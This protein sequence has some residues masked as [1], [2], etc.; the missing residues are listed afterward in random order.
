MVELKEKI[1]KIVAVELI[2]LF[3]L[4]LIKSF[5]TKTEGVICQTSMEIIVV[6]IP[7]AMLLYL[8]YKEKI[9]YVPLVLFVIGALIYSCNYSV[10][11]SVVDSDAHAYLFYISHGLNPPPYFGL[12]EGED[13]HYSVEIV[14]LSLLKRFTNTET[15]NLLHL[16]A[17]LNIGMLISGL[18][19]F[20]K[21]K[22]NSK[23]AGYFT[24][25][26]LIAWGVF[27][28][29]SRAYP[30]TGAWF[31]FYNDIFSLG[32]MFITL[33]L[34]LKNK[35]KLSIICG[36]ICLINHL[37]IG[38]VMFFILLCLVF[39]NYLKER[40]KKVFKEYIIYVILTVIPL[41]IWPQY[42]IIKVLMAG[43]N[44]VQYQYVDITL[45]SIIYFIIKTLGFGIPL[46]LVT[47]KHDKFVAI[48]L[49]SLVLI[50]LEV[51]YYRRFI[52]PVAIGIHLT[53]AQYFAENK[54]F[55]KFCCVG[56]LFVISLISQPGI[57]G[58]NYASYKEPLDV[59]FLTEVVPENAV[60]LSDNW[61][62]YILQVYTNYKVTHTTRCFFGQTSDIFFEN[63][64][65]EWRFY[66]IRI[67]NV[68][69]I[70]LNKYVLEGYE[71][72]IFREIN[73]SCEIAY[74]DERCII[75]KVLDTKCGKTY[76]IT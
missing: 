34:F 42:S 32:L 64:S 61:T 51:P 74:E 43:L 5:Y 30:I 21:T 3:T 25:F 50:F 54:S 14:F 15:R 31:F 59:S 57:T 11:F 44:A 28:P 48:L 10:A 9:K 8:F 69:Y 47:Y 12:G 7:I 36:V 52:I 16:S 62:D 29:A 26:S 71:E 63:E 55:K 33:S 18:Y 39:E 4:I 75:L 73:H 37:V 45:I 40:S 35:K 24:L 1:K 56:F 60:I 38:G 22:Y 68:Q 65:R 23:T 49:F 66:L 46:F 76:Q 53:I 58:F 72:D 2:L 41:F 27:S 13:A 19:F 17:I 67:Y 70:L 20:A 6:I